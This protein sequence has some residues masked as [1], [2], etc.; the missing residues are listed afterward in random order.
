[1]LPLFYT[2]ATKKKSVRRYFVDVLIFFFCHQEIISWY[3][4][5]ICL[6]YFFPLAF[7]WYICYP[8]GFR[9]GQRANR[10]FLFGEGYCLAGSLLHGVA[11]QPPRWA[12]IVLNMWYWS[13][14]FFCVGLCIRSL[15]RVV[16]DGWGGT[17]RVDG[18]RYTGRNDC[19][20]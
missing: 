6:A 14:V 10:S 2:L 7:V 20:W 8:C 15:L 3:S 5:F 1:M 4:Y 9:Q 13:E 11:C 12:C 17:R 18:L 19:T 16:V